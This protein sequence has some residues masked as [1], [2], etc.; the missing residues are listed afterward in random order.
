MDFDFLKDSK[1]VML[2]VLNVPLYVIYFKLIFGN[3]LSFGDSWRQADQSDF[4]S[5]FKGNLLD[6]W[7]HTAK[8]IAWLFLCYKSVMYEYDYFFAN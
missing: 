3:L 6:D 4:V 1:M 5:L 2:I 7:W 8:I